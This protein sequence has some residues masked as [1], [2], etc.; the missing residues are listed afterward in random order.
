[1]ATWKALLADLRTD[2]KDTGTT[3]R[4][5]DAT[6][7]LFAKDAVRAYSVDLPN[8]VFRETLTAADG[9]FT[10]P[11]ECIGIISVES[12]E[13]VYLERFEPKVGK[14]VRLSSAIVSYYTSGGKL[15][16]NTTPTNGDTVMM[17]YKAVYDLPISEE[18]DDT[19]INIPIE[20]EEIVRLFVKAKIS[21]QMR[22]GQSSLDRFKPGS[23]ARDD[24]PL[25]PEHNELMREYHE[26]I[27]QRLGGMIPLNRHGRFS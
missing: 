26:R 24:N 17:T 12:S 1:M 23:G 10:L 22:L 25:L 2:L 9:V 16:L 11:T 15:Y 7:Y 3:P 20:D 19:I 13:G 21:E 8:I 18:D 27:A 6:L 14:R 5:S 4:W